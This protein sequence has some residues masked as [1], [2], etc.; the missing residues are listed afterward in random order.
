[1]LGSNIRGRSLVDP[2]CRPFFEATSERHGVISLHPM[3]PIEGWLYRDYAPAPLLGF[4]NGTNV[5]VAGMIFDR[6]FDRYPDIGLI[7]P[8][9]GASLPYLAK[10]LNNGYR[11]YPECRAHIEDLPSSY[12]RRLYYDTA[13]FHAPSLAF[14][15]DPVGADRI[16]LG[17]AWPP[18]IGDMEGALRTVRALTFA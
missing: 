5:A 12:L 1:M 16:L 14:A 3:A 4:I 18:V 9:M 8:H 17:S 15:I 13:S 11:A 7:V 2:A 6:F 10:R